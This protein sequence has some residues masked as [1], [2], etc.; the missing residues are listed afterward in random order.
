MPRLMADNDV[1]GHLE[2]LLNICRSAEWRDVWAVLEVTIES[3]ESVGLSRNASDRDLW[4]ICQ[5]REILLITGNRN[6][7]GPFSLEATIQLL[8]TASSLPV[9][10]IGKPGHVYFDH[11]YAKQA[12]IRLMEFLMNVDLFRGTGRLYLP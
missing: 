2:V 11:E 10:T 1:G 9:L 5:R 3:F 7:M 12:A 4:E 8:G 6:R